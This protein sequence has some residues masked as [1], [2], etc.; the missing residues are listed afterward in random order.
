MNGRTVS[1][2]AVLDSGKVIGHYTNIPI[3]LEYKQ[4]TFNSMLCTDMATDIQFRGQGIISALSKRVYDDVRR[5]E[6]DMS[7]GYSNSEGVQMDLHS[8]SYGYSV[9]GRFVT[10]VK[11]ILTA[12]KT[13]IT[14]ALRDSFDLIDTLPASNF[15]RI[16][17]NREYLQWRYSDKPGNDF[18]IYQ[19]NLSNKKIGYIVLRFKPNVCYVFDILVDD[20]HF[21]MIL[22]ALEE[23][24]LSKNYRILLLHVCDNSYWMKLLYKFGYIRQRL[25]SKE[26]YLTLKIHNQ[27]VDKELFSRSENWFL[28]NG[29]IL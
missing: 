1:Y 20:I 6:Y 25:F 16:H 28:I 3:Q 19:V 12:K 4:T 15:I 23:F 5:N 8:L 29:D 21:S 14:F 27:R 22:S 11:V 17:K 13:E 7:F 26:R 9:V 2:L 24:A 18:K 10:Y